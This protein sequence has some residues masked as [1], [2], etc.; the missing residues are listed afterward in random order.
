MDYRPD[1]NRT[2][3]ELFNDGENL[4]AYEYFGAHKAVRKDKQGV[5]CRRAFQRRRKSAR[6]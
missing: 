5:H 6:V 1:D 3:A 2:A 4:R